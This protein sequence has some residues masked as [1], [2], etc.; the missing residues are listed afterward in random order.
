M[1]ELDDI[2]EA[3]AGVAETGP[4]AVLASVVAVSGSTYRQPGARMLLLPGGERVGLVSGGCLEDD[5]A[6]RAAEVRVRRQPRLVCYDATGADDIVW[7]LGLG[8]AGRME[9]LLEPVD[10]RHPG[11]LAW[12]ASWRKARATGAL[13]T[14]LEGAEIGRRWAL[15][16]DGRFEDPVAREGSPAQEIRALLQGALRTGRRG[17]VAAPGGDLALEIARP[18]P[19]LVVF[20]AGP[21]AR[22]VVRLATDLGWSVVV[23]DGRPVYARPALFPGARVHC[24]PAE[25]AVATAGVGHGDAALVMTHHYLHDRSLL[26]ELLPG[27]AAYVG[28]LGPRQRALDLLEDLT[29][30]GCHPS[31][32]QL[33]RFHAP[34]GLDLGGEGPEAIALSLVAEVQAVHEGR[35]G[36]WLRDRKGPI[37]ETTPA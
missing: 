32:E 37:H 6:E 8:C 22:P 29:R 15:H 2:L 26:R 12:L 36:G 35:R 27:P 4:P 9:V 5:L 20:G 13:A 1:R 28:L 25:R 24:A 11:P 14:R 33:A 31:P 19:R 21:D 16:P 17:R 30:A 23:V 7:G 3:V 18:P 10:A 34:A